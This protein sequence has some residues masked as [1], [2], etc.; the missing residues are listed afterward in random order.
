M[1]DIVPEYFENGQIYITNAESIKKGVIITEDTLPFIE[2]KI[3][4]QIDIDEPEDIYFAEFIL[5][6]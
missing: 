1:Q 5:N 2:D 4:A 6:H 3:G